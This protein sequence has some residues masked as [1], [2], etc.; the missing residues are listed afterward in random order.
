MMRPRLLL[1]TALMLGACATPAVP[2]APAA[3]PAPASLAGTRWIG[4]LE[5]GADPQHVPRIEFFEGRMHGFTGCNMMSGAWRMEEG[6]ARLGRVTVTRRM[7]LGPEREVEK[8]LMA[9]LGDKSRALRDGDRLV[10]EA[11]GGARFE[12]TEVKAS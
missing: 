4:V 5:P 11:P 6:E 7:C 3:A 10:I 12:F 1:L 9:A 2:Q 8:R